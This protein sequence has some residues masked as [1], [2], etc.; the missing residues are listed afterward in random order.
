MPAAGDLSLATQ[1]QALAFG[2]HGV[3]SSKTIY[4][5]WQT[6][7]A[8]RS[9]TTAIQ[10]DTHFTHFAGANFPADIG[11]LSHPNTS[12][13][14]AIL[15]LAVAS[16]DAPLLV[17]MEMKSPIITPT[18]TTQGTRKNV[19]LISDMPNGGWARRRSGVSANFIEF[20]LGIVGVNIIPTF[21]ANNTS[22]IRFYSYWDAPAN[23][24]GVSH[25]RQAY[26]MSAKIRDVVTAPVP[27]S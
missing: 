14:E 25:N 5:E 6:T 19:A 18:Q 10:T 23:P 13:I 24:S 17:S 9:Q 21:G 4:W 8:P 7:N 26:L 20:K 22:R 16:F 27:E 12:S 3:V 1:T 11:W 2:P 15:Y